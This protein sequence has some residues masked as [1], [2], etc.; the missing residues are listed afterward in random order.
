LACCSSAVITGKIQTGSSTP[1]F[2]GR[3]R[4]VTGTRP[5]SGGPTTALF[6]LKL[7]VPQ[8][9]DGPPLTRTGER[10]AHGNVSFQGL[11]GADGRI[12]DLEPLAASVWS[13]F[14]PDLVR[15]IVESQRRQQ[16]RPARLNN[17]PI[18]TVL[19][20]VLQTNDK[21]EGVN[22]Q[23]V[24]LPHDVAIDHAAATLTTR[25]TTPLGVEIVVYALDGTATRTRLV[26]AAP[27]AV[28]WEHTSRWE[29]DRLVTSTVAATGGGTRE[30]RTE[31]RWLEG[32][33]MVVETTWTLREGVPPIVKKLTYQKADSARTRR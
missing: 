9:V 16:F 17:V 11:I 5:V 15:V 1:N 25:R 18:A 20:S 19:N 12:A 3:W 13:G 33:T 23:A 28:E 14:L 30:Q 4:V 7:T 32:A 31:T 8:Q 6:G 29:G 21:P 27:T 2:S 22:A 24:A 26:L 10:P